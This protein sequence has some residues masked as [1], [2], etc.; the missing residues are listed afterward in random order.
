MINDEARLQSDFNY[1][2]TT[3]AI[4]SQTPNPSNGCTCLKEPGSCPCKNGEQAPMNFVYVLGTMDVRIPDQSIAEELHRIADTKKLN[5]DQGEDF[6]SWCYRILT[7]GEGRCDVRYIARM[8]DWVP[9]VEGTPAYY[10]ALRDPYDLQE[11]IDLL[12]H[13]RVRRHGETSSD[14]SDDSEGGVHGLSKS[15]ARRTK[16]Q[17]QS[18]PHYNVDA[19]TAYDLSLCIGTSSMIPVEKYP[20]IVMPVLTVDYLYSFE[21]DKFI[22]W[23]TADKTPELP[24][25]TASK[26]L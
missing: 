18:E 24:D 13:P 8:L 1:K 19:D 9:T 12:D 23:F 7:D 10:V 22:S 6:R 14:T 21:R 17:V 2:I 4:S 5:R 15:K 25:Q 11:L 16:T 3:P 26:I 20:G